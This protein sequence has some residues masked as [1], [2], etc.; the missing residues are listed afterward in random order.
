MDKAKYNLGVQG[1]HILVI[2]GSGAIGSEIVRSQVANGAKGIT[3]TYNSN[4]TAAEALQAEIQAEGVSV[5]I[6]Q[7]DM[8]NTASFDLFL[9]EAVQSVGLEFDAA[10]IASGTSPNTPFDEQTIEQYRKIYE[11]N[12]F[13][14]TL[15]A[16]S[17]A[18]RMKA[19]GVKGSI[20]FVTSTNGKDSN[21]PHSNHYDGSKSALWPTIRNMA[22][23][24]GKHNIRTNGIAPGWIDTAMNDDVPDLKDEIKK[25]YLGR[26][27][28]AAEVGNLATFLCSDASSFVNG[29]DWE[30]DGGY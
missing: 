25:I 29:E 26:Q 5:Y 11:I 1:K 20:V 10:V 24:Y 22:K 17:I 13:G 12:T 8:V 30:I 15:A 18:N 28:T 4:K 6:A 14:P 3:I 2:G 23:M 16:R 9:E 21:A 7:V 27:G 19:K